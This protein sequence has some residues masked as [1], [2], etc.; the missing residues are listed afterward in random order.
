MDTS[1]DLT[2]CNRKG[3]D[4]ALYYDTANAADC[5]TPVWVFNKAVLKTVRDA[6]SLELLEKIGV[7]GV[8][9]LADP[10][11]AFASAFVK[12]ITPALLIE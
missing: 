4:M 7:T 10:A 5:A 2:L 6:R 1:T 8:V 3:R 11:F 9:Q 12:P